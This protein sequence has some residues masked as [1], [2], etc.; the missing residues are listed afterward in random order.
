VKRPVQSWCEK[1]SQV[2]Q[3]GRDGED[4]SGIEAIQKG[5]RRQFWTHGG[6]AR[7]PWS[8]K[9]HELQLIEIDRQPVVPKPLYHLTS[10]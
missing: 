6:E 2:P 5:D 10:C 7:L 3:A 1:D 8:M 4:M 9:E